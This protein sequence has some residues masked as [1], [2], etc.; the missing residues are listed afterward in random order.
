MES[1]VLKLA[2]LTLAFSCALTFSQGMRAQQ[3]ETWADYSMMNTRR[4]AQIWAEGVAISQYAWAP[5]L[6][7]ESHIYWGDPFQWPPQYHERFIDDGEWIMLDGWWGN[8]TYYKV[9]ITEEKICDST[10]TNCIIIA[11]SGPQHYTKRNVSS[12]TYCLKAEGSV[13]E[14]SSGNMFHFGHTQVYWAPTICSNAYISNQRCI[15]Q[16]ESWWDDNGTTYQ[17]K[18]DRDG[19]LAKGIGPGFKIYQYFPTPWQAD[20]R[21][22]WDY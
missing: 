12:S 5:Q 21:Y 14:Q 20:L 19:Y 18:V 17:R 9:R 1:F 10:C 22:Y 11:S 6:S 7:G 4:A 3:V 13:T 8:G 2:R 15:R 16:W